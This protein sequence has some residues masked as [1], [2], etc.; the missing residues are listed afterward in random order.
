M[1][2]AILDDPDLVKAQVREA[3]SDYYLVKIGRLVPYLL[4]KRR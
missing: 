4:S 2:M 1:N 3:R